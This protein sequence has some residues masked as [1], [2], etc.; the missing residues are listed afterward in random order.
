M[1]IS[2]FPWHVYVTKENDQ[3]IL[4]KALDDYIQG[5]WTYLDLETCSENS[6]KNMPD[7]E[8]DLLNLCIEATKVR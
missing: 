4:D 1:K 8:K 5:D 6:N 2:Q 7:E 3:I